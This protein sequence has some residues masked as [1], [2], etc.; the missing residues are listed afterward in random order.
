MYIFYTWNQEGS[1]N[2]L[3]TTDLKEYEMLEDQEVGKMEQTYFEDN[4]DVLMNPC[5]IE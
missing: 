4:D 2:V 1:S 3:W 5:F